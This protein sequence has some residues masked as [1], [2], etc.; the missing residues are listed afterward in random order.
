MRAA[1]LVALLALPAGA[2]KIRL[3]GP[4]SGGGGGIPDP[5]RNDV[6]V[7]YTATGPNGLTTSPQSSPAALGACAALAGAYVSAIPVGESAPRPY[8][9]DGVAWRRT[10]TDADGTLPNADVNVPGYAFIAQAPSDAYA[11]RITNNG[12][13]LD[14]GGGSNDYLWSDGSQIISESSV[15]LQSGQSLTANIIGSTSGGLIQLFPGSWV[16]YQ[17]VGG[18]P[19]CDASANGGL[20][21]LSGDSRLY[22]CD[23]ATALR[24]SRSLAPAAVVIDPGNM[25]PGTCTTLTGA[26]TGATTADVSVSVSPGAALTSGLLLGNT[27]VSA[28]NTVS[29]DL[30]NVTTATSID[31]PST[32]FNLTV[33]R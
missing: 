1:L 13:R 16:V 6:A 15:R 33:F 3:E 4:A 25:L 9:C 5:S 7:S 23:G 28:A 29:F 26:V 12:A 2:Q 11:F 17:S 19:T 32:T 24:L 8:F 14:L 27:R 31:Q 18:L 20:I 22:Y 30:C 10:Y 21:R